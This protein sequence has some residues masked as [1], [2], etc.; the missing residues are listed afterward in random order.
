MNADAS[1]GSE[2][3]STCGGGWPI[4]TGFSA[5]ACKANICCGSAP[6]AS[7]PPPHAVNAAAAPSGTAMSRQENSSCSESTSL[8]CM[9]HPFPRGQC[10]TQLP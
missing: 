9:R 5:A 4:S 3:A 8:D 10:P 6:I 2:A 7:S 1:G